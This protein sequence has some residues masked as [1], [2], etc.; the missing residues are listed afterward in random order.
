MIGSHVY[1]RR[2]V[3]RG[4]DGANNRY[5]CTRSLG[6][7]EE[8]RASERHLKRAMFPVPPH[9]P[10]KSPSLHNRGSGGG[11]LGSCAKRKLCPSARPSIQSLLVVSLDSRQ[12]WYGRG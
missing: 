2:S 8:E 12:A 7:A 9:P 5:N 10:T 4:M 1:F 11:F 3:G 6:L